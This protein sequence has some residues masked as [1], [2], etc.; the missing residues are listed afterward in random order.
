MFGVR[1]PL[2]SS[3][4]WPCWSSRFTALSPVS[5][6]GWHTRY[7]A[8][9]CCFEHWVVQYG[10]SRGSFLRGNGEEDNVLVIHCCATN[11]PK[12]SGL[13]QQETLIIS[14][15][16]CGSGIREWLGWPVLAWSLKHCGHAWA[17]AAVKK[18]WLRLGHPLPRGSLIHLAS[19]CWL[20]W[21]ET[22]L[23]SHRGPPQGCISVLKTWWLTSSR[24][25]G[26]RGRNQE[27]AITFYVLASKVRAPLLPHSMQ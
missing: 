1:D 15:I 14:H 26:P 19:W 12:L 23:P 20:W 9:M 24:V 11:Y 22:S 6:L 27:E 16:C 2:S 7:S 25:S 13:I 5:G 3:G 21:W 17:G 18:A 8:E 10:W 4:Q